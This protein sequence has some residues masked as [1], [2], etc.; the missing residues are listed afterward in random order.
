MALPSR[1]SVV[2]LFLPVD[3]SPSLSSLVMEPEL[4]YGGASFS[5]LLADAV[6][7]SA[8][9]ALPRRAEEEEDPTNGEWKRGGKEATLSLGQSQTAIPMVNQMPAIAFP[10]G[11][12]R[13]IEQGTYSS[14]FIASKADT[15]RI[16]ALNKVCVNKFEPKSNRFMAREIQML[17]KLGHPNGYHLVQTSNSLTSEP[18]SIMST[19]TRFDIEKFD[20]KISFSIWRIQMRAVLTQNGL[21]KTLKGKSKKP[22]TMTDEQWEE[23]DEKALSAIQ[24]CLTR[25]VLREVIHETTTAGLWLKLESQYMTKSLA[26]KLRL[27]D[28]LYSLRMQEGTPIQSHLDEFNSIIIDLENLD[29][30]IED[31]DKAVLL[32]VSL[33]R[34]Y[35]HFKEIMLYG[36]RETIS[37]ED[38]KSNLMSKEK[39]DADSSPGE[40]AEGLM[41]R[42]RNSGRDC[43]K[44]K[45]KLE[46]EEKAKGKKIEKNA[47]ADVV[48]NDSD[49]D[50][51]L[52]TDTEQRD[53][54]AKKCIFIGYPSGVKGYRLW[55]PDP[56]SKR[57]I[58]SRDVTF[59]EN[60]FLSS[61]RESVVSSTDAGNQVD[62]SKKVDFEIQSDIP[63]PAQTSSTDT[64][65]SC[66]PVSTDVITDPQQHDYTIARDRLR[67]E[68]RKPIRFD[69]ESHFV[70]YALTV[71]Q[72]ID[73]DLEPRNYAE[74][75]SC[76]KSEK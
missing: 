2:S 68:I 69:D 29:I 14:V 64:Q 67:R 40:T 26:N 36:N 45:N 60:A 57:I 18:S 28:R 63:K 32:I 24:L 22:A 61:G 10:V 48:E 74:A 56:N 16:V 41:V 37:L 1:S 19:V 71:A 66:V 3:F 23:L 49:G 15:G 76:G 13:R 17:H 54:R 5:Q 73:R 39:F 7:P 65:S 44:L 50:V 9:A 38:V 72:E 25:E 4:D 21:K 34:T 58:I 52:A 30:K 59:N 51:L 11:S 43:Y 35:K 8:A 53:P 20:G 46:R 62:E 55:C 31:E 12:A 33:P 27:K 70:A 42:G 6:G 75:I 47:E